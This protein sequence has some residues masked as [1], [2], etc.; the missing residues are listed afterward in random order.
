MKQ[1]NQFYLEFQ[2]VDNDKNILTN[3]NVA[4][5][6]FYIGDLKR[7]Y[8]PESTEVTY[9]ESKQCYKIWLTEAETL[10]FK[11][12]DVDARV[13]FTT[14]EILGCY[15]TQLYFNEVLVNESILEV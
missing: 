4:K 5:I 8:T 10:Q 9:D 6:V 3:T 13:L 12:V 2:L 15:K 1:G 14:G 11:T 7:T